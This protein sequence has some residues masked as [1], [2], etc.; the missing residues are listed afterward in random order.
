MLMSLKQVRKNYGNTPK[1]FNQISTSSVSEA[2]W[3]EEVY[4]NI[5]LSQAF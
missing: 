2:E 1:T 5:L 3:K 4:E